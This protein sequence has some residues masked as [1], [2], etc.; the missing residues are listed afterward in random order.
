MGETGVIISS[1]FG[2][3]TG[4]MA[5]LVFTAAASAIAVDPVL[6]QALKWERGYSMLA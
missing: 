5:K 2:A 3:I 1:E 6:A 4:I